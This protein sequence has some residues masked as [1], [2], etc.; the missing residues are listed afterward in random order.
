[1]LWSLENAFLPTNRMNFIQVPDRSHPDHPSL[2]H[3]LPI[4]LSQY[5]LSPSFLPL[6]TP[7]SPSQPLSPPLPPTLTA[8]TRNVTPRC[9]AALR[10]AIHGWLPV[11]RVSSATH[12]SL[13]SQYTQKLLGISPK[14]EDSILQSAH[15]PRHPH[16]TPDW[17]ADP[18][19][20]VDHADVY[21]TCPLC[22]VSIALWAGVVVSSFQHPNVPNNVIVEA[23]PSPVHHTPPPIH[24]PHP[25]SPP[26][27]AVPVPPALQLRSS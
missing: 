21:V 5:L 10:L 13:A 26:P 12:Q 27:P 2:R 18:A 14:T 25:Q 19:Q 11:R 17:V 3:P 9:R 24:L 8:A 4:A 7:P 23:P 1:M 15:L 22:D 16:D 6:S 20:V